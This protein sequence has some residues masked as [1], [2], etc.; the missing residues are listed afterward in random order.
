ME[1]MD[2]IHLT[3]NF[4]FHFFFLSPPLP[5]PPLSIAVNQVP[6]AWSAVA[7]P[8]L[9]PCAAWSE[10]LVERLHFIQGTFCS[11][12]NHHIHIHFFQSMLLLI[13]TKDVRN[14]F[15]CF[16]FRESMMNIM[17]NLSYLTSPNLM[18]FS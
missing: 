9:K 6:L 17:I 12:V 2:I 5:S 11:T 10:D 1:Y 18:Y 14:V 16:L 4:H 3:V 15:N 7:Y 13:I 8:S